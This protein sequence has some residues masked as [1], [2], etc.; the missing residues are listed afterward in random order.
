VVVAPVS[1]AGP[2]Q[3]KV[4][5]ATVR[6][7]TTGRMKPSTVSRMM[8]GSARTMPWIL[9]VSIAAMAVEPDPTP[10]RGHIGQLQSAFVQDDAEHVL[11]RAA[12]A[13][14]ADHHA[15]HIGRPL[16]GA[17]L[18]GGRPSTIGER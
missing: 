6:V 18:V 5:P 1:A 4:W 7:S 13:G 14:H 15:F 12:G 3:T 8:T 17:R 10:D 11:G 9:P 16:I 2:P